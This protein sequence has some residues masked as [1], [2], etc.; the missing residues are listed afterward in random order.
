MAALQVIKGVEG[1]AQHIRDNELPAD[2][3][4]QNPGRI[5]LVSLVLKGTRAHAQG[6]KVEAD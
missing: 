3:G 2:Q 6:W 4:C 1:L 5:P